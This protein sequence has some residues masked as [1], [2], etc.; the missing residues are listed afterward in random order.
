MSGGIGCAWGG[1][2]L[3]PIHS[4]AVIHPGALLGEGVAVGPCAVIEDDVVLG[5]GCSIGA[6]A[7]IKRYARLGRGNR[8]YEHAVIGGDPQDFKFQPCVSRVEIGDNNLIREG[9]TIHRGSTEG[10]ATAIGHGNFLMAHVSV[11]SG[12]PPAPSYSRTPPAKK[13]AMRAF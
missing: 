3:N 13:F 5:D 9:V 2:F 4:T 6:H 1:S 10:A 11:Q 7:V 12:Q 8:V